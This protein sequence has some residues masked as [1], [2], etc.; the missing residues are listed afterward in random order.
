MRCIKKNVF[1]VFTLALGLVL[2]WAQTGWADQGQCAE[3][4]AN[5]LLFSVV[6]LLSGDL[7]LFLG[8]G[9]TTIGVVQILSSGVNV[10]SFAMIILGVSFT[11]LPSLF[12][13]V[14]DGTQ[15]AL[16]DLGAGLG[17]I[18]PMSPNLSETACQE[19]YIQQVNPAL[20]ACLE[21]SNSPE[22]TQA[23]AVCAEDDQSEACKAQQLTPGELGENVIQTARGG[24]ICADNVGFVSPSGFSIINNGTFR[25]ASPGYGDARYRADGSFKYRHGGLDV[26]CPGGNQ[27][28]GGC[29]VNSPCSGTVQAVRRGSS[30]GGGNRVQIRCD[31]GGSW[32]LMHLEYNSMNSLSVGSS[33]SEG[34]V[35]GRVG[36]TGGYATG[37]TSV[38]AHVHAQYHPNSANMASSGAGN[39]FTSGAAL[40]PG[41]TPI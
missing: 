30:S 15:S 22:C 18:S 26:Y 34:S 8:L 14:L 1:P 41:A 23:Q 37:V 24:Y 9:I 11:A 36:A 5:E 17:V 31:G 3:A 4:L 39:P 28:A 21:N 10:A 25:G 13:S 19:E 2:L 35:V 16:S 38:D 40:C 29:N 7:G 27:R 20:R 32:N 12:M 33:I 6:D